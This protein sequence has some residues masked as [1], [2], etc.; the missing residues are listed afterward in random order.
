MKVKVSRCNDKVELPSY[1]TAGS[2]GFDF[3]ANNFKIIAVGKYIEGMGMGE[4]LISVHDNSEVTFR[5]GDRLK[6]GTGIKMEIPKGYELQVRPRSGMAW[7]Q[8]ITIMNSPGTIDSDFRGEVDIILINHGNFNL[9][10]KLGGRIAQGVLNKIEQCEWLEEAL[11][12]TERGSNGF[13][14]TNK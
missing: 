8:G 2:A 7:S 9:K 11:N 10:L 5:P 14:S 12:T 4:E 6:I 3:I 13:G 1:Q